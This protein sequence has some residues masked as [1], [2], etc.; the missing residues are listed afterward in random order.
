MVSVADITSVTR[1]MEKIRGTQPQR[2]TVSAARRK[3][4]IPY[5]RADRLDMYR[6]EGFSV[7]LDPTP[8]GNC[9]FEAMAEQLRRIG[10]YRSITSL[11]REIVNDLQ[12]RPTTSDGTSLES[13]VHDSDIQ[14]YLDEMDK[15]G[16]YGDHVTLQRASVMYNVQFIV[17]SSI[18]PHA[19]QIVSPS[20]RYS[21]EL[22]TLLVLSHFAEGDGKHY[23]SLNGPQHEYIEAMEFEEVCE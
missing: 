3:Y 13:F 1:H 2:R 19:T 4:Y 9:Q 10:I 21:P 12:H 17:L 22:Q 7:Q 20:G 11:R 8:D 18:G 6:A 14:T 5:Q 16:T 15:S 23:V